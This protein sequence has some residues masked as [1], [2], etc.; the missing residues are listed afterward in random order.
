MAASAAAAIFGGI[1]GI[2]PGANWHVHTAFAAGEPGN[3]I[4]P[5]RVVEITMRERDG[6]MIFVPAAIEVRTGEHIRFVLKNEGEFDHEF[7]LD[8]FDRNAKRRIE[9]EKNPVMEH[10]Y[11]NTTR[12]TAKKSAKIHWRFTKAGTFEF[13]DLHP[14]HYDAGMK[15]VVV[16]TDGPS[17]R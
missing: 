15:G 4:K 10:D 2:G 17:I 1:V 13:A 16:V 8:S 11:P 7:V 6:E 12:I 14:D 3:S 5:A 9:M